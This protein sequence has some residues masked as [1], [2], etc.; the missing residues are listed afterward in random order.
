M[1]WRPSQTNAIPQTLC[2]EGNAEKGN[3]VSVRCRKLRSK[4]DSKWIG[5]S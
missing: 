3:V 4:H 2:R 5:L 1:G